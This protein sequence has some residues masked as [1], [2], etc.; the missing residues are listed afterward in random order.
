MGSDKSARCFHDRPQV[1]H[2]FELLSGLCE[3]VFVSVRL[4]HKDKEVLEGLALILDA[5]SAR[6]PMAGVASAMQAHPHAAW[7][8]LACDMPLVGAALLARLVEQ[9]DP[10]RA[11]TAFLGDDGAPEPLCAV[12]EPRIAK[13]ID[14]RMREEGRHSLRHLLRTEDVQLLPAPEHNVLES[15]NTQDD[16]ATANTRIRA[17]KKQGIL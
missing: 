10:A 11:A 17:F 9:R 12:Y 3:S 13:V 14:R 16:L 5:D 6:G 4:E 15:A 7:L 8:V 2:C 1:R